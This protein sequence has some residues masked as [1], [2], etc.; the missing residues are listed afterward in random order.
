MNERQSVGTDDMND[1][2]LREQ[3]LDE[4]GGVKECRVGR[5]FENEKHQREG[6]IVK[7]GADRADE[8]DEAADFPDGPFVRLLQPFCI[9]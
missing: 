2:C 3:A 7:D 1:Q 6:Q 4:P 5:A 9:H 8:E